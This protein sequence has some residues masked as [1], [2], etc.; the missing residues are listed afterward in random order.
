M[1]RHWSSLVL[2]TVLAAVAPVAHLMAQTTRTVRSAVTEPSAPRVAPDFELL[3]SDGHRARLA[4]YRGRVVLVDF[5]ATTCGGCVEEIPVFI[6]VNRTFDRRG[7]ATLGIAEDIAYANLSGPDEAWARVRPFVR[8]QRM[9]YRILMGDAV[10]TAQYKIQALPLTYLVDRT[11]RI[12]A[13]YHGVVD[14]QNLEANIRVL[15]GEA[16]R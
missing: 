13:E 11:G 8:D 16:A 5:W 10:V 6:E 12:A 2:I 7:L 1:T 3:D 14:R 15:L 9:S 4:D